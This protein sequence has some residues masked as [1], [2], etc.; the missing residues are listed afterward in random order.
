MAK[1]PKDDSK[2]GRIKQLLTVAK[3]VHKANPKAL[4]IVALI[5]IATIVVVVVIGWFA[6]SLL[7]SIPLAILAGVAVAMIVFGRY[8]QSAQYKMLDGQPGAALAIL[9]SM[10]GDWTVER[11]VTAN[12]NMDVVH[13]VVGRR[14]V[15]LVGEG[16]PSRLSGLLAAEKKRV[17]RVLYDVTIYD[18]QV[19]D[20]EGQVP[21][22]KLQ[23]HI[24]KL[25][26]NMSKAQVAE[27]NYRLKAL[28]ASMQAPK[29]PIPKG[30][31]M[32]K[33]PKPRAK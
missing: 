31:K 1:K 8:A 9:E 10:R 4:P 2:P 19:G 18:V 17:S 3:V 11:A 30:V 16:E 25:P 12:R 21:I 33:G 6:G 29:G 32:P 20:H 7:F 22:R 14:G 23:S 28:P 24:T 26:S 27:V 15:I 13:R 5:G